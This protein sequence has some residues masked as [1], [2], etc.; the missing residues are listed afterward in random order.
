MAEIDQP[1]SRQC[2]C[3]HVF[4]LCEHDGRAPF[5]LVGVGTASLEGARSRWWTL[6]PNPTLKGGEFQ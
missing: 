6:R 4:P 2:M 5:G 3:F 1:R